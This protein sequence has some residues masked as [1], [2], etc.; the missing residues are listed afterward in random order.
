MTD[1][2]A[3]LFVAWAGLRGGDSMVLALALPLQTAS[4]A[5]FPAREQIIFDTFC[6]IPITLVLQGSTLA[7]LIRRLRLGV[8]GEEEA[9]ES[10]ARLA[11]T[12]AGLQTLDD[13]VIAASPYPEVPRYLRQRQRQ[14]VRR[15]A[16]SGAYATEGRDNIT[17][18]RQIQIPR[19]RRGRH[20]EQRAAEYRRVRSAM[21]AAEQNAVMEL[22]NNGEIAD[23]VMRRIQ[24]ELDLETMQLATKDPVSET[25]GD[26]LSAT[27]VPSR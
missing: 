23:S 21:L 16:S 24:R 5:R 9:E 12:R 26:V 10:R 7:P 17:R 22:R 4:G 3:V 1:R 6:V 25:A 18:R 19:P 2:E 20:D 13:S 8:E 11:V 15:W 27:D 14:R